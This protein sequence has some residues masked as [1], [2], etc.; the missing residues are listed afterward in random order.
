MCYV[1]KEKENN[2]KKIVHTCNYTVYNESFVKH[3]LEKNV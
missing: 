2:R 3:E 1:K